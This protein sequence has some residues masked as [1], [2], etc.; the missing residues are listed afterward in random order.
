MKKMKKSLAAFATDLGGAIQLYYFV[1]KNPKLKNFV[2]YFSFIGDSKFL[3]KKKYD[4][5]VNEL[6]YDLIICA[7]SLNDYEKKILDLAIQKKRNTW[8][9]FD[10]WTN[11]EKRLVYKKKKLI[12]SK[13]LVSDIYAKKLAR[14]I[15]PKLTI[16]KIPNY[17]LRNLKKKIKRKL[18]KKKDIQNV[19]YYSSPE[20]Y[21][22]GIEKKMWED[23]EEKKLVQEIKYILDS[24]IFNSNRRKLVIRLHPKLNYLRNKKTFK[25]KKFIEKEKINMEST[26]SS[27]DISIG[28]DTYALFLTKSLGIPTF[29]LVKNL[30]NRRL[31]F[32]INIDSL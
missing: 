29:S 19:V 28:K 5:D 9:I 10:N 2:K 15:Y 32:P 30:Y 8:V 4:V 7:T 18:S 23:S 3:V 22:L 6:D 27:T 31:N 25:Y 14:K 17:L 20:F 13:L 21:P 16:E 24:D 12:P 1:K 26:I 11:F